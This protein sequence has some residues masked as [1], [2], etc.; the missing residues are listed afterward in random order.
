MSCVWSGRSTRKMF[1]GLRSRLND[2]GAV[3]RVEGREHSFENGDR[4]PSLQL[5]AP[6]QQLV[7]RLP[8]EQLHD[9]STAPPRG[10]FRTRRCR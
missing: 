5:V 4:L 10:S 3:C 2:A 9:E 7:E 6:L 8:L 1:D